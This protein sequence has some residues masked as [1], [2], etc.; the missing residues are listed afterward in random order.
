M[1]RLVILMLQLAAISAG[2]FAAAQEVGGDNYVIYQNLDSG[3]YI[4]H[5][6]WNIS[7]TS[8]IVVV[9]NDW[10]EQYFY[11]RNT[12][13]GRTV[14]S[15][16]NGVTRREISNVGDGKFKLLNYSTVTDGD[17]LTIE[18]SGLLDSAAAPGF[19]EYTPFMLQTAPLKDAVFTAE[20]ADGSTVSG[21]FNEVKEHGYEWIPPFRKLRMLSSEKSSE[22]IIE[23][24]EGGPLRATELRNNPWFERTY[25]IRLGT[26]IPLTP[27]KTMK[28][29]IRVVCRL[30]TDGSTA[31]VAAVSA[32]ENKK[33][34]SIYSDRY[35]DDAS[36]PD[37]FSP[38]VRTL[39]E[40]RYVIGSGSRGM[41]LTA[42]ENVSAADCA[43]LERA[44]GR[45]FSD[46]G[47]EPAVN[48][49]ITGGDGGGDAFSIAVDGDGVKIISGNCRGAFYALQ[50][51]KW[52]VRDG[53]IDC[54][55]IVERPAFDY[56]GVMFFSASGSL[57]FNKTL[58][59]RVYAPFR[60][61]NLVVEVSRAHWDSTPELR[62]ANGI[63]KAELK[64][65]IAYAK[66]NFIEVSPHLSTLG[67]CDWLFDNGS[68]LDL[69]EDPGRPYAYFTSNPRLYPLMLKLFDEICDT[70]GNPRYFHI[71]HDEWLMSGRYPLR[72]ETK[73]QTLQD[74]FYKDVMTYHD[75][76]AGRGVRLMMWQDMLV[77]YDETKPS[78]V[79]AGGPPHNLAELRKKL[80]KD[81]VIADWRYETE[82]EYRDVAALCRD[83]FPVIGCP[84]NEPGNVEKLSR[85]VRDCGGVGMLQTTWAGFFPRETVMRGE[86]SQIASYIR[87]GV[88]SWN[89]DN[90]DIDYFDAMRRVWLRNRALPS[91]P[92]LA[93]RLPGVKSNDASL[94]PAGTTF[95]CGYVD[96]VFFDRFDGGT[97]KLR[98]RLQPNSPDSVV[99]PVNA[100]AEKL[101]FLH[102][103]RLIPSEP[104]GKAGSYTLNYA[105]GTMEKI[106]VNA[107]ADVQPLTGVATLMPGVAAYPGADERLRGWSADNPHPEKEI[108]SITAANEW[109]LLPFE[110]LALTLE[111]RP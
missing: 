90:P 79:G 32:G 94:L 49:E 13:G 30:V 9:N 17:E 1:R 33:L 65:L 110:L 47:C 35:L 39:G 64:E 15:S 84:W 25:G 14:Q 4:A 77:T 29:V 100:R 104:A 36:F 51:L 61:S 41:K 18:V 31:E 23:V 60:I 101:H 46:I 85:F 74:I 83:G 66:E 97:V 50:S 68:N 56:R 105:D 73:A 55:T 89:P 69:A 76:A 93:V 21:D 81:I 22:L 43:K 75:H 95:L 67:H 27:G 28:H 82:D 24:V 11:D 99:I 19:M 52:L 6:L 37:L 107:P 10:S 40:G 44:A 70:F 80:P 87:A 111:Q 42:A 2:V 108:S 58:I 103:T 96:G 102:A 71:G 78:S 98:S 7:E 34:P 54:Q 59:D 63:S 12:K 62:N 106:V 109:R 5:R 16:E 48:V 72:S 53:G 38:S 8:R 86:F 3:T 45:I 20:L 92:G 26:D 88:F 57:E 91:A